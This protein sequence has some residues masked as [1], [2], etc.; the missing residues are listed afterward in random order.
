MEKY[1]Q[2]I[3]SL[4]NLI[5]QQIRQIAKE[6]CGCN[7]CSTCK[8]WAVLN[9]GVDLLD[10]NEK[11]CKYLCAYGEMHEEKM[12]RAFLAINNQQNI[13]NQD[14]TIIDWGCGQGL[15]TVCF[16]DYLNKNKIENKTKKV[17]L[18]EPSEMALNRAKLHINAYLKDE[19]KIQATN[20]YLDDD[21]I[22]DIKA[23]TDI[24]L[25]FFSNILDIKYINLQKLAKLIGTNVVGEHYFFC[26]SPLCKGC[27]RID[28]FYSYFNSP[29]MLSDFEDNNAIEILCDEVDN[30]RSR[31]MKLKLFKFERDKDYFYD[32]LQQ[33]ISNTFDFPSELSENI[34]QTIKDILKSEYIIISKYRHTNWLEHYIF[35]KEKENSLF[36]IHFNGKN[37][38]VRIEKPVNATEFSEKIFDKI[39]NL[40]G[41]RITSQLEMKFEFNK[42]FLQNFYDKLKIVLDS[43]DF[44]I[45]DIEHKDWHEI[46]E[47]KRNNHIATYK[48][49]Y[50]RKDKFTR[51]EIIPQR[52]NGL[53]DEINELLKKTNEYVL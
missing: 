19:N 50:N 28:T 18:I 30:Q 27:E 10:T 38:I 43:A 21:T 35:E 46:Y 44:Q 2:Q 51:T 45:A 4:T 12:Q 7:H 41:Q 48:F 53:T 29:E 16:F 23:N 36:R 47:I 39:K 42:P 32:K 20:K 52:T 11:L 49:W 17:I 8:P 9:H 40:Q 33:T 3:Q 1:T 24:V 31:T 25:H 22:E 5:F 14:I 34:Y 26:V 15:A 6:N 37:K 13:F